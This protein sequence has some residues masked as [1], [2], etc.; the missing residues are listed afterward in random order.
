MTVTEANWVVP[1]TMQTVP[2][3]SGVLSAVNAYG[4]SMASVPAAQTEGDSVADAEVA[5]IKMAPKAPA[6]TTEPRLSFRDFFTGKL[7]YVWAEGVW[8][9]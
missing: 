3:S 1:D 6:T 7:L 8:F 2:A 5:G 9:G 4:T